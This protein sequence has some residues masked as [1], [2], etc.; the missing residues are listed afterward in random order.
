M[1]NGQPQETA[2]EGDWPQITGVKYISLTSHMGM[3]LL[4]SRLSCLFSVVQNTVGL[5]T[6]V[7]ISLVGLVRL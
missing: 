1:T 7:I 5:D 4:C 3:V 2:V 6:G